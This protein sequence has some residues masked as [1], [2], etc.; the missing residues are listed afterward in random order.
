[1]GKQFPGRVPD[2]GRAIAQHHAASSFGETAPRGFA[3]HSLGELRAVGTGV[4]GSGAFDGGGIGDRSGIAHRLAFGI[5]GLGGPHGN[6]LSLAGFGGT[7]RLLACATHNFSRAHGHSGTVHP[8][9]HGGHHFAHLFY[10]TMFIRSDFLTQR[11]GSSFRLLDAYLHAG[12]LLQ[13][14]TALLEAH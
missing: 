8:Q 10:A 11:F 2:P 5:A 14:R 1:M 3:Q 7:V 13:Q 6:Y 4:R 12:Q 9:I